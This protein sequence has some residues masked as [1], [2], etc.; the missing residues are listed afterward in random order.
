MTLPIQDAARHVVPFELATARLTL[1]LVAGDEAMPRLRRGCD[2]TVEARAP[3]PRPDWVKLDVYDGGR[4]IG[5]VGLLFDDESPTQ[6]GYRIDAEHRRSGYAT[7]ALRALLGLAFGPFAQ[8]ELAAEAAE[9]NI[10]SQRTLAR[11]GFE[12]LGQCG[13][14]WSQRRGA[15]V[16]YRRYRLVRAS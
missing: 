16:M 15:Y 12:D 3:E 8:S 4:R 1:R 11:L 5:D 10:A 7:E 9:D 13:A 14:Q 2:G 6:I